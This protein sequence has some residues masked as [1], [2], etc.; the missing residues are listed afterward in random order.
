MLFID[1]SFVLYLSKYRHPNAS[2]R[3]Q[4]SDLLQALLKSV[5]ELLEVPTEDVP[6]D[7]QAAVLGAPL[8]EASQLYT[9]LQN[10][11]SNT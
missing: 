9:H 1:M 6:A 5:D 11:Y 10:T 3:P 7:S 4:P 2:S 8:N